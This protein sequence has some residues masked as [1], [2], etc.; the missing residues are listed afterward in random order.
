MNK[1]RSSIRRLMILPMQLTR[2]RQI[3]KMPPQRKKRP[4]RNISQTKK[5][6]LKKK[7]SKE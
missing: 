3:K 1:R 2:E 5:N 4:K 6:K 7:K